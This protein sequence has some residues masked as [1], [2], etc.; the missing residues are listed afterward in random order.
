M[1][2]VMMYKN[3]RND[4]EK[5]MNDIYKDMN[6]Y[7]NKGFFTKL[8]ELARNLEIIYRKAPREFQ[9]ELAG[10]FYKLL[11]LTEDDE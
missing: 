11:C 4:Y 8:D 1:M 2:E 6:E 10:G 5:K 9:D 7:M 3:P